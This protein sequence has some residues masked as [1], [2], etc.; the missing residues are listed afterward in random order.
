MKKLIWISLASFS[1]GVAV[2]FKILN[3]ARPAP[4]VPGNN[5]PA[6]E[7]VKPPDGIVYLEKELDAST[8]IGIVPIDSTSCGDDHGVIFQE[9]QF[10][11]HL[12]VATGTT[13]TGNAE[14]LLEV[15]TKTCLFQELSPDQPVGYLASKGCVQYIDSE[16]GEEERKIALFY[17]GAGELR[18]CACTSLSDVVFVLTG[19]YYGL[20]GTLVDFLKGKVNGHSV[21]IIDD[22]L[23][24]FEDAIR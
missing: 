22:S 12:A 15:K 10:T 5:V 2:G 8:I 19:D 18:A 11:R 1:L 6:S 3:P 7:K 24:K 23:K 21:G 9:P 13:V 17:G 20:S 16:R 14:I 4:A